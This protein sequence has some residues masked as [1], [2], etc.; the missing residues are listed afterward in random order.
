[1]YMQFRVFISNFIIKPI[2]LFIFLLFQELK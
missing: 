1:M 2:Y